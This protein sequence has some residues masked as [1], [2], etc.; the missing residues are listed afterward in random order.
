[1]E[2]QAILE[3]IAV[4][5]VTSELLD[6]CVAL[7]LLREKTNNICKIELTFVTAILNEITNRLFPLGIMNRMKDVFIFVITTI[8]FDAF[9]E[10]ATG[11]SVSMV[12]RN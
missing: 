3:I 4:S 7:L 10:V 8:E 12:S 11:T 6:H 1:M 2:I 5:S 9:V